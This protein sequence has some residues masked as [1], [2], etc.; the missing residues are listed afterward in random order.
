[1]F[2]LYTK[3]RSARSKMDVYISREVGLDWLKWCHVCIYTICKRTHNLTHTRVSTHMSMC[4]SGQTSV[5]EFLLKQDS[6]IVNAVDR[7]GGTPYD[8]AVR[9]NNRGAA[10]L[11]EQAG[12]LGTGHPDLEQV[13]AQIKV[14]SIIAEKKACEP[15]IIRILQNRY[16]GIRTYIIYIHLYI[17]IHTYIYTYIYIYKHT[18]IYIYIHTYICMHIYVYIYI[19]MYIYM[20][21][22]TYVYIHI[23]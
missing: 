21:I 22:Y 5:L 6:I 23:Y 9:H 20:Y 13:S 8:D 14:D 10:A 17:Y 11:L 3:V 12:C 15:K 2:A 7:F 19:Y 1:M 16:M 18:Y 4:N